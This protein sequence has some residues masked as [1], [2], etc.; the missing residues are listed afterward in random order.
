MT[1]SKPQTRGGTGRFKMFCPNCGLVYSKDKPQTKTMP[2]ICVFCLNVFDKG[3]DHVLV[4][5]Q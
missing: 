4:S 1:S 3:K 5:L 2:W